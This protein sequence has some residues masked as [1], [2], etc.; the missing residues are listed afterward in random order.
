MG[1]N[2]PEK[3]GV[4]EQGS[5]STQSEWGPLLM[6]GVV[7]VIAGI[8]ATLSPLVTGVTVSILLGLLLVIVGLIEV[9][10]AFRGQTLRGEIWHLLLG[11]ISIVAGAGLLSRPITGLLT[12]TLLVIFYLSAAGVAEIAIGLRLRPERQWVWSAASGLLSF[13]LAFMLWVG[14]PSSGLWAVGLLVGVHLVV[15][16]ASMV[17]VA[18]E[19]RRTHLSLEIE[20]TGGAGSN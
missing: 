3:N 13:A 11:G 6:T 8:L 18:L 7:V 2:A 14:F 9:V 12:V 4:I 20:V 17:A 16:G 10:G 15:T 5:T 19:V 1:T